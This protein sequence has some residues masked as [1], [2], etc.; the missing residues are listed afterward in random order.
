MHTRKIVLGLLLLLVG[1]AACDESPVSLPEPA[2]VTV[3]AATMALA[4]GDVAPV[5]A[6]VVDQDGRVMQ[7]QAVVYSTDNPSVAT[8]DADGM[9]HAVAPGTANVSAAHGGSVAK[10][11]I[12]VTAPTLRVTVPNATM[13][14]VVG[15]SAPAGAQVLDP[16][17]RVVQGATP[18]FTS[19][20]PSVATVDQGGVVRAVTPGTARISAAYGSANATVTVTVARDERTF[21]QTLDV[22]ADSLVV[23]VRGGVQTLGLRAFNGM[24]EPVC[25]AAQ[26]RTS[27]ASV[28]I[29]SSP[30]GCRIL[31]DPRFPGTATITVSADGVV[32]SVRVRVTNQGAAAFFSS[33]PAAEEI[34]AANTVTYGVRLVD[35]AG[36]PLAGR[37][38]NFAVTGGTLASASVATDSQGIATVQWTLPGNLQALGRTHTLAY[39]TQLPSGALA[40]G[41]EQV[42]VEAG[43]VVSIRA[44]H[45]DFTLAR[46]LLVEEGVTVSGSTSSYL[47]IGT[48]SVDRFGNASLADLTFSATPNVTLCS[49]DG[50][51]FS[52]GFEYT[53]LYTASPA[54]A[55]LTAHAP[56]G[57]T[58]DV[59]AE[60]K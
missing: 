52:D 15:E 41:S 42:T 23:D 29:G 51:E 35:A 6:Q 39:S 27:D 20:N 19:D 40:S 44:Y 48:R 33:R 38:V 2:G 10:V 36:N 58:R 7:G 26:V 60:F 43:P 37:T 25:P 11:A 53:C 3:A 24:G 54:T 45:Y 1:A 46:W 59:Q 22:L 4:V 55:T 57:V 28:A 30:G 34:F 12:T 13:G 31:V 47:Y 5:A 18:V 16:S 17:G 49:T 32:D 14:L 56:N 9:V 50:W 21:V 8:V